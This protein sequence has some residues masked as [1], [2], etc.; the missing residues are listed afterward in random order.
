VN[1][2]EGTELTDPTNVE[3]KEATD[4]SARSNRWERFLTEFEESV[5]QFQFQIFG[6][7][8]HLAEQTDERLKITVPRSFHKE[9]LEEKQENKFHE[10]IRDVYG[11]NLKAEVEVVDRATD[12][13]TS[14][15]NKKENDN[16]NINNNSSEASAPSKSSDGCFPFARSNDFNPDHTFDNFVVG[17]TNE[18]AYSAARA[19]AEDPVNNFNPLFIY[20]GVGLGK[21]HLLHAIGHEV[22]STW[23]QA[24]VKCINAEQFTNEII[25]AIREGNTKDFK[26]NYRNVDM[27]LV[28]DVQFLAKTDAAQEEFYHTFNALYE[29]G[30]GTV[31]CSDSPPEEIS[32]IEERLRSRFGMGLTVDIQPPGYET[33]VAILQ[34]KAEQ[35]GLTVPT[36]VIEY[37]AENL[38]G[39]V[40]QLESSLTRLGMKT[41]LSKERITVELAREELSDLFDS[42]G[43]GSRQP[44]TLESI[45]ETVA[46]HFGISVS[47]LES[48]KRTRAIAEPRQIAMYLAR[49]RTNHSYEEIGRAFGDRDHSTVI[50]AQQK[51]ESARS[52]EPDSD[53]S[54]HVRKL[55]K[56]L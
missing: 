23:S 51:I 2:T 33:R 44:L 5:G 42:A 48:K 14:S 10:T 55:E 7:H 30:K 53:L 32:T 4:Q 41:S 25:N 20:G 31:F 17:D 11:D 18:Y 6:N 28:D 45:Q 16:N 50:H 1:K 46:E 8:L 38:A 54:H 9:W 21:T 34:Q 47:D 24:N 12:Q 26:Y 27:F 36:N 19:M 35:E 29:K 40:R 13:P 52:D 43:S 49:E 22:D 3:N 37:I 39:N 56:E 15:D